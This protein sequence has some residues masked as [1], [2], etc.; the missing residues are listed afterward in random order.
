[1]EI[2]RKQYAIK[3]CEGMYY[4]GEV[5]VYEIDKGYRKRKIIESCENANEAELFDVRKDAK[6]IA[7]KYN[8]KVVSIN[9]YIEE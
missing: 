2:I 5:E 3:T 9:T 7:Q 6:S 4:V 1:M 8:F